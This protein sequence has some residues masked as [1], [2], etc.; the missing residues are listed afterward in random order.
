M[1][2]KNTLLFVAIFGLLVVF[3]AVITLCKEVSAAEVTSTSTNE[4]TNSL[5]LVGPIHQH[6]PGKQKVTTDVRTSPNVPGLP[7]LDNPGYFGPYPGQGPNILE[8]SILPFLLSIDNGWEV[9]RDHWWTSSD[10]KFSLEKVTKK[11]YPRQESVKVVNGIQ[12]LQGINYE[13]IATLVTYDGIKATTMDCLKESIYQT[14]KNGGN[15]FL[16][17]RAGNVPGVYSHT[18]GLGGSGAGNLYQGGNAAYSA[19]SAIGF[20]CNKGHPVYSPYL[21]GVVLLVDD[22]TYENLHPNF[23]LFSDDT[24]S[25]RKK[26][27][28]D[29]LSTVIRK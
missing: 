8:T 2:K 10:A 22:K 14:S 23:F 1:P 18:I 24:K 27:S 26:L 4:N 21:H 13:V 9:I 7:Y 20:A 19:G 16:L 6:V 29:E 11:V 5:T 3:F 12:N 17:L 15:V 25:T 28:K